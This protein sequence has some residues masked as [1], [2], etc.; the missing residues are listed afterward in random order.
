[1]HSNVHAPV[2]YNL[3]SS[4]VYRY[5]LTYPWY[6]TLL[7]ITPDQDLNY[8]RFDHRLL[9]SVSIYFAQRY[10]IVIDHRQK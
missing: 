10:T 7:S 1:M 8:I 6:R 9:K 5:N 2:V 3:V 4:S